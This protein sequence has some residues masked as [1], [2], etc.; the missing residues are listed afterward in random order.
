MVW[1]KE[2]YV[3]ATKVQAN[4]LL[5][6]LKPRFFVEAHLAD[7]FGAETEELPNENEQQIS[8]TEAVS[9]EPAEQEETPLPAQLPV[10]LSQEEREALCQSNAARHDWIEQ[11]GA[12]NRRVTG[13]CYQRIADLRVSTTDPDATIMSWMEANRASS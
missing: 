5:D 3:D 13:R 1:G 9:N 12:Q 6:S 2:L 11:Q 7:L 10:S 8:Q 4:A